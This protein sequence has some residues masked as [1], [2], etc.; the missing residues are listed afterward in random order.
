[1]LY[2]EIAGDES[3][4][5][6]NN[7]FIPGARYV[8]TLEHCLASISKWESIWEKSFFTEEPKSLEELLS[9]FACMSMDDR[10]DPKA[11]EYLN[12]EHIDR[13]KDYMDR[14]MTAT[15]FSDT[16]KPSREIIT[17]EIIYHRMLINGVPLECQYW[18][19]NKLL[20]LLHV[21][22]IENGSAKNK[23]SRSEF[24]ARRKALNEARKK[25]LNTKG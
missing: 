1:M 4:D 12:A 24:L 14:K 23:M 19:I 11:F 18:H 15:T 6:K 2:L 20:T 21:Y 25:R 22:G 16:L 13:I 17:S 3:Y 9:Y 10:A 8:L 5:E 7:L